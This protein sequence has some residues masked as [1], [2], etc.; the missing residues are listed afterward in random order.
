MK[1]FNGRSY[2]ARVLFNSPVEA[3]RIKTALNIP[4]IRMPAVLAFL[5]APGTRRPWFF[6][7]VT[8]NGVDKPPVGTSVL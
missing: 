8:A 6:N 7:Y 2:I 5:Y 4:A 1:S 3:R